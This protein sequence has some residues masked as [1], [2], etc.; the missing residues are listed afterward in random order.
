MP[1]QSDQSPGKNVASPN[2][3]TCYLVDQNSDL[4]KNVA[5]PDLKMLLGEGGKRAKRGKNSLMRYG[6]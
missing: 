5:S 3:Q 2:P 1:N 6:D 4:R